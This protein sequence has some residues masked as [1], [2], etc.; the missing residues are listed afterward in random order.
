[1]GPVLPLDG[2]LLDEF[3]ISLMNETGKGLILGTINYMSPEQAKGDRVDERTDIFSLGVV[4]YEMLTGRAPFAG[5]SNS[6]TLA[7]LINQEPE[8]LS[9]FG[10]FYYPWWRLSLRLLC[11]PADLR[12]RISHRISDFPA[13]LSDP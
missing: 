13:N 9:R 4:I 1:M 10:G 7:N 8:P 6:E 3:E 12:R 5:D 2:F 11:F